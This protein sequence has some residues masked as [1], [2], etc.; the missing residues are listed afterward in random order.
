MF[1]FL[2]ALTIYVATAQAHPAMMPVD[3]SL[4]SRS[5]LPIAANVERQI[6]SVVRVPVK[7]DSARIGVETSSR[8]AYIMDWRTGQTLMKKNADTAYPIASIT[9][10]MTALVVMDTG[11]SLDSSIEVLPQDMRSGGIQY[12]APGE[13]IR[14]SDLLHAS[15][16]ASDNGAT[17][18]LSRST[19]LS[20]EEFV[21]RMNSL[22]SDLGMTETRFVEPTGLNPENVSSARDVALL[23]RRSLQNDFIHSI[24]VMGEYSFDAVSG[25]RHR[26]QST[27]ELLG[28]WVSRPPLSFLGGKTGYLEEAGYCFGA[29]AED[30]DGNRIVTVVL[31][32]PTKQIRF[33]DVGALIFWAFDAFG[34]SVGS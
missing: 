21:A 18:T 10:L 8:A 16:I 24:V 29:A 11:V 19:G 26:L 14:V 25:F 22:A 28:G 33:D 13:V 6:A 5:F 34:W 23:V 3:L 31:G 27:D 2:L 20:E 1:T 17:V 7:K 30:Q 4:Q 32:A 9:K 15:L 12:V